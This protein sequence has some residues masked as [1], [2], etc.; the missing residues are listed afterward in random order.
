MT[1]GGGERLWAGKSR[2]EKRP[3]SRTEGTL[4]LSTGQ[5]SPS[6]S[7]S[8]KGREAAGRDGRVRRAVN[9]FTSGQRGAESSPAAEPRPPLQSRISGMLRR[10]LLPRQPS[11][12]GREEAARGRP[13]PLLRSASELTGPPVRRPP[14]RS[15]S[16][17]RH[18][19]TRKSIR[20]SKSSVG[21]SQRLRP[22]PPPRPP[23][24]GSS[25][26][27]AASNKSSSSA[28]SSPTSTT[29]PTP[30]R[31]P[32]RRSSA[33]QS[34]T[35][36][37]AQPEVSKGR[38]A[39]PAA[40]RRVPAAR[41]SGAAQTA[42]NGSVV[43]GS[44]ALRSVSSVSGRRVTASVSPSTGPTPTARTRA[45][46]DAGSGG[47]TALCVRQG[48]EQHRRYSRHPS[49]AHPGHCHRSGGG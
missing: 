42:V 11:F 18:D 48:G 36:T 19:I 1:G 7:G 30:P 14:Q 13:P 22:T 15:D 10:H 31:P 9:L 16:L 12:S 28:A 5:K 27:P 6:E 25:L 49:I 4:G 41:N 23:L 44:P 2:F 24:L 45:R 32:P 17:S 29:S 43:G 39:T 33:Q 20:R 40:S 3:P 47:S 8:G 26:S 46:D 37:P 35:A 34:R 38:A 21:D